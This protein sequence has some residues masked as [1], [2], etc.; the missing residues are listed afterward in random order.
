MKNTQN[1]VS[2]V[3]PTYKRADKLNR[4]LESCL[5][6]TYEN[7]EI[8]VVDDNVEGSSY[9][10]ETEKTMKKYLEQKKVKY[11]KM[12]KNGG[13]AAARNFGID[14]ATG[15]YIA[16]LD[17][18]DEF[19]YNK[20]EKHLNFMI[21]NN[22]DAS[23]SNQRVL[24]EQSGQLIYETKHKN[25][26][27][28]FN[29]KQVLVYHLTDMI[30][31]T[32]TFMYKKDALLKVGKFDIVPSGQEYILMYKTIIEG[33][34]IGHLDS[35]LVNI[36]I[37][38]NERISTSKRKLEGEKNLYKIKRKHFNVLNFSQKRQ[39][40]YELLINHYRYYKK[41]KSVKFLFYLIITIFNHPIKV[42]N[43]FNKRNA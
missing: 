33:L 23:F 5:K 34:K 19:V 30:I 6:Q 14:N 27:N 2:I 9:R 18:D 1:K 17:D 8:I 26:D 36:Y 15:D 10:N 39:V 3:I 37:H 12:K 43:R 21:S 31:G 42:I 41:N 20:I 13:G 24:N 25:F 35:T 7:I 16:F 40:K 4:A 32:Q 28:S 29:Q 38:E 11:I 22:L